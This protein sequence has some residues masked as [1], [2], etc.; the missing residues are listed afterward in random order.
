VEVAPRQNWEA[1]EIQ[2]PPQLRARNKRASSHMDLHYGNS[3]DL[4]RS[5]RES[6]HFRSRSF[7]EI[8]EDELLEAARL[9]RE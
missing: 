4:P 1:I 6:H 2:E 7:S 3:R 9:A 5:P 8:N